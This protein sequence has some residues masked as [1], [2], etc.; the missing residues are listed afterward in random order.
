MSGGLYFVDTTDPANPI[1]G[2]ITL[3]KFALNNATYTVNISTTLPDGVTPRYTLTVGGQSFPF[4]TDNTVTVDLTTFTFNTDGS[5][6]YA[7][8]DNPA[9]SEAPSP[10]TL[11]PF[12]IALGGIS[13]TIDVFNQPGGLANI[14]LGAIGRTYSYDPIHGTVTVAQGATKTPV[15]VQTGLTLVSNSNYGYVIGINTGLYTVNGGPGYLYSASLQ[16]SPAFYPLMTAPQMFTLGGNFYTFDQDANGNYL[17]VTGNNQTYLINP[18][19][20]SINGAVYVIDTNVQPNTVVGGGNVYPMTA[21]NTQFVIN[22]VQYTIALKSGSLNGATVSGQFNIT[23]GNVIVIENYVYQLDTLNSQIVGNGT[24]YPLTT[25]GFTYTIAAANQSF[26]VTTEPNTA[27]VTIGGIVYQINNT[28]V[29]GD[30]VAYPILSYRSFADGAAA[31]NIGNDG[32]VSTP[33]QFT[34]P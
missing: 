9:M 4:S 30:G 6:T 29:V 15:S 2:V 10:I 11:T 27:T 19:Q 17:S 28:T 32:I 8:T 25:S 5:V 14:V 20:F 22:G 24:A 3:P 7:A 21:G 33:T 16:G 23:Q 26:T 1:Y 34:L 12:S 18:Y 31:F 13:A